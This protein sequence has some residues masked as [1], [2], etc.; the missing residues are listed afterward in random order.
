MPGGDTMVSWLKRKRGKHIEP[1]LP[2]PVVHFTPAA[3]AKLVELLEAKD[4][5]GRGALRVLVQNPGQGRPDYGMAIEETGEPRADDTIIESDR[6]RVFVDALSLTEVDGAT[7][8]FVDDL[9]RP[10]FTIE[11]PYQAHAGHS[12]A[13]HDHAGHDHAG[14]GHEGHDHASHGHAAHGET[15]GRPQLDLSDPVVG[16]IASVL[17]RQINPGIASHGGRAS[18][19][20]VRDDV[21]YV[22]LSGGCQGCSMAAATL[23]Q[24]VEQMIRQAVPSI[25]SVVDVTDHAGGSNPYFS[26]AK[27]GAQ[28][29]FQ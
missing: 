3:S 15:D 10:G 6:F 12:H 23:K 24:G 20:A 16:A 26:P 2:P 14:H 28:S 18:L 9:L 4:C 22:E 8:D 17:E 13:G 19:L 21:A 27:G 11:P 29:P 7:V 25:R 5:L 1:E